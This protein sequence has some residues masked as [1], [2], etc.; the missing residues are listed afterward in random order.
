ML[1]MPSVIVIY[2]MQRL[3]LLKVC[4]LCAI[5]CFF[6]YCYLYSYVLFHNI[7]I[8]IETKQEVRNKP[9]LQNICVCVKHRPATDDLNRKTDTDNV[10][11]SLQGDRVLDKGKYSN[12][13]Y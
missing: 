9:Y 7:C 6:V 3:K 5:Y 10:V 13:L 4:N 12:N 8:I 2:E 1:G 11:L